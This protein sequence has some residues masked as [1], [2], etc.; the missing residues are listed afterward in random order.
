MRSIKRRTANREHEIVFRRC[1]SFQELPPEL[2]EPGRSFVTEPPVKS[3][4]QSTARFAGPGI[5][6]VVIEPQLS[7]GGGEIAP[8]FAGFVEAND[9]QFHSRVYWII[10]PARV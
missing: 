2:L 10:F 5:D 6:D 8:H 4:P 1:T 7:C 3:S 9:Q